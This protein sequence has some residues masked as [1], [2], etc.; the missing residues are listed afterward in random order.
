[1][2]ADKQLYESPIKIPYRKLP[3]LLGKGIDWPL[4]DIGLKYKT[5]TIAPKMLALVD[6][7]A[8]DS[9]LDPQIAKYLGF[10]LDKLPK[11][12]GGTSASGKYF[13]RILPEPVEMEIYGRKFT[14]SFIVI[15]SPDQMWSCILGHNSIFRLSKITF[16]THKKYFEVGLRCDIN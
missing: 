13:Y 2:S 3:Q 11:I 5:K 9:I 4:I 12:P 16:N 14:G 15:D 10:D 8:S 1:M 6:S 7:G